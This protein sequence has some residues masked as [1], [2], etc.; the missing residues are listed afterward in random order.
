MICWCNSKTIIPI[1]SGNWLV[2]ENSSTSSNIHSTTPCC[3]R[4]LMYWNVRLTTSSICSASPVSFKLQQLSYGWPPMQSWKDIQCAL[5]LML[6][7]CWNVSH[8]LSNVSEFNS[9]HEK[10]KIQAA[11]YLPCTQ[12]I[13]PTCKHHKAAWHI[14][15]LKHNFS[16]PVWT[17]D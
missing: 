10:P 8:T 17:N 12:A 11:V 4:I 13:C 16:T 15:K 9:N 7:T 3:C 5:E 6:W 14:V 1:T 2:T